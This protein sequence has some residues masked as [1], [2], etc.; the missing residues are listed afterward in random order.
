MIFDVFSSQKHRMGEL[1]CG[2]GFPLYSTF[3]WAL[4]IS[5]HIDALSSQVLVAA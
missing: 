3:Y 5:I 1:G 4:V 2:G